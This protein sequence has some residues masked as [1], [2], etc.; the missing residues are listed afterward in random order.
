[1]TRPEALKLMLLS[2]RKRTHLLFS[3]LH[4]AEKYVREFSKF[5]K[6]ID[7]FKVSAVPF[8][9]SIISVLSEALLLKDK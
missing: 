6:L 3:S 1:V 5:H 4:E 9:C 7:T 8:H 2:R